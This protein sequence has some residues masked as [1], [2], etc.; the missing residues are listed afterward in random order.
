MI[1]DIQQVE[2]QIRRI[3]KTGSMGVALSRHCREERMSER[4]VDFQD[5]LNVLNWG[6]VIH[7]PDQKTDM[8]FKV[9]GEDLEGASLC[10]VVIILDENALFV[11]TVHG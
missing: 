4:N 5:I 8:K 11:K 10:V 9:I 6:K 3:T 2:S 7:D 1:L